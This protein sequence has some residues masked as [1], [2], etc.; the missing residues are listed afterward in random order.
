MSPKPIGLSI[1]AFYDA[2][3]RYLQLDDTA[4]AMPC[5]PS[6]RVALSKSAVTSPK[7]LPQRYARLTNAALE[8]RPADMAITMHLL[9]RHSAPPSSPRAA[10][11]SV[12]DHPLGQLGS[13]GYFLEYDTDRA[14][15]FEPLRYS[16]P[17]KQAAR[18]RPR[19]LEK[20]R[21]GEERR[22]QTSL[23]E[24]TKYGRARSA[25]PVA[26]MRFRFDRG[27]QRAFRGGAVGEASPR[28][29][30]SQRKCGADKS[31]SLRRRRRV[32]CRAAIPHERA[33]KQLLRRLRKAAVTC[34]DWKPCLNVPNLPIAPTMS[35]A[36]CARP[37]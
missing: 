18:A 21:A 17:G 14:C 13:D 31:F 1:R 25:P 11:N 30:R 10:T 29:S 26:A 4:W 34:K 6:E 37:R 22:Y 2:G 33:V 9:S 16:P 36:C 3:C 35:V 7:T 8:G 5:D 19:H 28:W 20:R 27:G 12:A 15:G 32:G 24:A 23:D